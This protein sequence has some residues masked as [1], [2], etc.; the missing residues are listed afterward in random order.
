MLSLQ[1]SECWLRKCTHTPPYL[2]RWHTTIIQNQP[3][4]TINQVNKN[5]LCHYN[6]NKTDQA[7]KIN[8]NK[9]SQKVTY[10]HSLLNKTAL[11]MFL[12]AGSQKIQCESTC[13]LPSLIIKLCYLKTVEN[14]SHP[15]WC[16]FFGSGSDLVLNQPFLVTVAPFHCACKSTCWIYITVCLMKQALTQK[17]S[18]W[19][20]F[21]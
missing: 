3:P 11:F 6:V 18:C 19:H 21:Y 16:L 10:W 9:P 7:N 1:T 8:K 15:C 17:H 20:K 2:S 13:I 4:K 14:I 12:G 5:Q